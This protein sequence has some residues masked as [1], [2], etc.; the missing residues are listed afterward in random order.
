MPNVLT[1]SDPTH[2]SP[3]VS[4]AQTAVRNPST[5]HHVIY[6]FTACPSQVMVSFAL[7]L[8]FLGKPLDSAIVNVKDILVVQRDKARHVRSAFH[9]KPTGAP[10]HGVSVA[11]G[12]TPEVGHPSRRRLN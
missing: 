11:V 7:T 4:V 3:S 1:S 10:D 12:L 9:G 8:P 2:L 5:I 6:H